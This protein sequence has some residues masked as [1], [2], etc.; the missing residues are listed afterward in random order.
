MRLSERGRE[1]YLREERYDAI[2]LVD[3]YRYRELI[4]MR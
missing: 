1:R 4:Y 2:F 3:I